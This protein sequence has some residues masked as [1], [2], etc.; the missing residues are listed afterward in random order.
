MQYKL[1]YRLVE[2]FIDGMLVIINYSM[3]SSSLITV[4]YSNKALV[5]MFCEQNS[6]KRELKF[7]Q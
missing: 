3:V 7:Q 5:F 6:K 1:V 4:H 2:F